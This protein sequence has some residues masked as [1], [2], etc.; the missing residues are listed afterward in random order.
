MNYHREPALLWTGF[1]RY[2][3]L[4]NCFCGV[5]D[6]RNAF[7]PCFQLGLLSEIITIANYRHVASRV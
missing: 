6:R 7:T 5:V 2:Y 3:E 4:M 1:Q